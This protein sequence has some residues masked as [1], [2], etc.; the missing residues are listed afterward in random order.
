MFE[1]IKSGWK[2]TKISFSM[3]MEEK[4]LMVFPFLSAIFSI[5]L[6]IGFFAPLSILKVLD[7]G[8]GALEGTSA[9][10]FFFVLF[11][12]YLGTSFLAIFFNVALVYAV[13]A[14]IE[15]DGASIG[16]AISFAMSRAGTI[17]PWAIISAIVGLI[18]NAIENSARKAKGGGAIVLMIIKGIIGLAWVILTFF[19]IPVIVYQNLGVIDTIK[20]SGEI[21]KKKWGEVL[22][23]NFGTGL[24]FFV[25]F[26]AWIIISAI[27]VFSTISINLWLGVIVGVFFFFGFLIIALIQSA[28]NQI[29]RTLIYLYA[30]KGVMPPGF[31]EAEVQNLFRK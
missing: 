10:L 21:M 28:I 5:L 2:L 3:L 15:G 4:K 7:F 24:F 22:F 26:L 6:L 25:L 16:Q 11:V 18:L 27:A 29:F 1:S 19:I 14:R 30:E 9:V 12:Y 31:S 8:A 23:L 13:K 20:K 17:L